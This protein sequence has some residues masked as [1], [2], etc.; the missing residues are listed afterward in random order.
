MR[1][2]RHHNNTGRTGTQRGSRYKEVRRIAERLRVP[3][4]KNLGRFAPCPGCGKEV[5]IWTDGREGHW[6]IPEKKGCRGRWCRVCGGVLPNK[7]GT[8]G[9]YAEKT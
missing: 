7:I 6:F 4:G 8:G 2:R 9:Q 1:R 5:L 3:Y